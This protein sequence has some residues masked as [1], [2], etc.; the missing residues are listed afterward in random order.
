ML[1]AGQHAETGALDP[2][3]EGVLAQPARD[4][5]VDGGG[6]RH[7]GGVVAVAGA[8]LEIARIQPAAVV[9]DADRR[10]REG[11]QPAGRAATGVVVDRD[12]DRVVG[13]AVGEVDALLQRQVTVAVTGHQDLVA[14]LGQQLLQ[15]LRDQQ[16]VVG[17]GTQRV[18]RAGVLAAVAGVDDDG[19]EVAGVGDVV[20][21]QHRIDQLGQVDAR[22]PR[23]AAVFL[24]LVAEDELHP[25]HQAFLGADAELHDDLLVLQHH[26][27]AVPLD[28][29]EAVELL[30]PVD[31]HVVAA[32]DLLDVPLRGGGR[33]CPEPAKHGGE[34]E[35]NGTAE[36]HGVSERKTGAA[37]RW[38]TPARFLSGSPRHDKPDFSARTFRFPR[39]RRF[40]RSAPW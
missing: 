5:T 25:V 18:G 4:R 22:D 35:G 8:H 32:A 23:A 40:L 12:E 21:P 38:P 33:A 31:I 24:D 28:R 14:A 17:F 1:D 19:A 7:V 6:Q 9:G 37:G 15:P 10:Q 2:A 16:V 13:D 27:V 36:R 20:R 26:L 30:H 34:Q 3:V 39:R 11:F 29:V